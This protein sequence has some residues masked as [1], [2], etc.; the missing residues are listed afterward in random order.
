[1]ATEQTV[2]QHAGGYQQPTA[3]TAGAKTQVSG[4]ATTVSA[5]AGATGGVGAGNLITPDIDQKLYKFKSDDTPMMQIMLHSKRVNVKS[6][7]VRHY[8]IDEPKSFVTTKDAVAKSTNNQFILPLLSQ[9]QKLPRPYTTLLVKGVDGYD[10][11]G[12]KAT[13]GKDL[14]IFIVGRDTTTGNPVA[15][16]VNGPRAVSSDEN[17]TT[18]AIPAGSVC[19]LMA[20]ACYETQKEVDPDLITPQPVDLHLQKRILNRVV[21]DYFD[22]QEKQ[23]P[24][25]QAIIAEAQITNFKVKGNRTLYAGQKGK[26][27]VETKLGPQD[28]Y[29]TEGA[30]YQVKKEIKDDGKWNFKKFIALAKLIF[31]GEDVPSTILGLCGKNFLEKIQTI[32]FSDHPEVRFEVNMNNLGWEVTRIH[33]IFG[34]LEFKHDPTLDRLRWS[35]SCFMIAYDRCVHYVYSAEHT[36]KDRVEGEEATRNSTIV[37]DGLGLKGTCHVWI[38]GEGGTD[39]YGTDVI[40]MHLWNSDKAPAT[41]KENCVYYLMV[42]CLAINAEAVSGTVWQYKNSAWEPYTGEIP[43]GN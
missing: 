32:D 34:N 27:T 16:A 31:T 2:Q 18:P 26:I 24:F 43:L 38:D 19:V 1:M 5:T 35:N 40:H 7:V 4:Q 22:A 6:P 11:E 42:D 9:D 15:I 36:D 29:F 39:N 33:T 17:C 3:G 20:N 30:R 41:P 10:A 37:W 28:V 14:M 8:I 25:N 12:Q 23:I 13:P 21:S